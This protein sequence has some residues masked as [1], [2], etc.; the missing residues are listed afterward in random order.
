[1][2]GY[3]GGEGASFRR[4]RLLQS[5][6]NVGVHS[7]NFQRSAVVG[8]TPG[9][10]VI[11]WWNGSKTHVAQCDLRIPSVSRGV[12]VLSKAE[13]LGIGVGEAS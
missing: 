4:L 1:M 9:I 13:F 11:R 8:D 5:I 2:G 10:K 3:G 7:Q 12:E 6:I